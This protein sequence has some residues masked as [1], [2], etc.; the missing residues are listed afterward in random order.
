MRNSVVLQAIGVNSR[1][2]SEGLTVGQC[3][4]L[5]GVSKPTARKVLTRLDA[6]G[7]VHERVHRWRS[8]A[9]ISVYVLS[10]KSRK[11][12]LKGEYRKE[13]EAFLRERSNATVNPEQMR[14]F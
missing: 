2:G 5:L 7:L 1:T 11:R 13:Y 6:S 3:A 9:T 4:K 10:I 12:F 8:N 14:L